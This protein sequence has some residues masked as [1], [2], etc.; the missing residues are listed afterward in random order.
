MET[1]SKYSDSADGVISIWLDKYQEIFSDFDPRD[2]DHRII[3]DDFLNE[4]RN[5][6]GDLNRK[7]SELKL[8]MPKNSRDT[9]VEKIISER[10]GEF[11]RGKYRRVQNEISGFRKKGIIYILS[12]II[13]L[14]IVNYFLLM[15]SGQLT[16]KIIFVVLEPG[17]WFLIWVGLENVFLLPRANEKDCNFFKKMSE[18]KI[19][20]SEY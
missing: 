12:G 3:S 6:Y 9:K 19:A 8:L 11:F 1:N 14:V 18:I 17:G 20:F 7:I 10:L 15:N 5:I 4:T 16:L 2:Y 13:L